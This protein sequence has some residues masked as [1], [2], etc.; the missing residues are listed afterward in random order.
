[1]NVEIDS[2]NEDST[3]TL[4]AHNQM[5]ST[6]VVNMNEITNLL[7]NNNSQQTWFSSAQD[8]WSVPFSTAGFD[9]TFPSALSGNGLDQWPAYT[10][11]SAQ[12]PDALAALTTTDAAFM[13]PITTSS[14]IDRLEHTVWADA[15][16]HHRTESSTASQLSASSTRFAK[17]SKAD[18]IADLQN[19][20]PRDSQA[21]KQLVQVFFSAIHP[22]WPILHAPTFK[23]EDASHDL[24]GAMLMLASWLQDL[25]DHVELA[26]LVFDAVTATLLVRLDLDTSL[27]VFG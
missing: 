18:H 14:Q 5:M 16:S 13:S 24:L 23:I 11:T 2:V 17:S 12:A 22:H 10:V 20:L 27:I 4:N 8:S 1:M 9:A 3:S 15:E 6:D 7:P 25:P 26:P 19:G 21:T